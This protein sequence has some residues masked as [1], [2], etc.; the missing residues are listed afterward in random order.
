MSPT[1][2][3]FLPNAPSSGSDF[4]L[5]PC[6]N[7]GIALVARAAVNLARCEHYLSDDEVARPN[8]MVEQTLYALAFSEQ[9]EIEYLPDSYLVSLQPCTDMRKLIARH[10]AGASRSLFTREGLPALIEAGFLEKLNVAE[11]KRGVIHLYCELACAQLLIDPLATW[12]IISGEYPPQEG[13]VADYTR[14]VALGLAARGDRV[15]VW[16]PAVMIAEPAEAGVEVHRLPGG[17][18]PRTLAALGRGLDAAGPGQILVQYVPQGFGMK[19]MNLPLCWWLFARRRAGI[20][21][22]FHEVAVALAWRQ[23]MRHNVIGV[24][25]RAMAFVLMRAARRCF[26]GAAAWEPLLRPLAPAGA[27]ISWLPVPSN[28][29]VVDDP[30]GVRAIRK[31]LMVEGGMVAWPFRHRAR[32]L[33]RGAARGRRAAAAARAPQTRYFFWSAATAPTFEAACWPELPNCTRACA[34]RVRSRPPTPRVIWAPATDAAAVRR[35][36]QHAPQQHDGRAGASPPRGNHLRPPHRAV[37]EAKRRGGSGGH[38][39][40]RGDGRRA[41]ASDGRCRGTCAAG[42]CGRRAIRAAFRYRAHYRRPARGL[43][44]VGLRRSAGQRGDRDL[45]PARLS[46]QRDRECRKR[47]LSQRRNHRDRRLGTDVNRE[48]AGSFADPRIVY[49][50]NETISGAAANHIHAFRN[51]V[52]GRIHRDSQ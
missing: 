18:G 40:H 52:V 34:P 14:L 48:I 24:V 46:A 33:D 8:T 50:R 10:Y 28:V 5:A 43:A 37:V 29:P 45:Q 32:E 7:S 4:H 26:V 9:C 2:I 30:A 15:H 36:R 47:R 11:L 42:S 31:T 38:R 23:P 13:G 44:D 51:L 39:R 49:H 12:H 21:I 17:F 1:C 41:N 16:A 25:H 6:V 20:T 22:M 35:W 19:G 27:A 3:I